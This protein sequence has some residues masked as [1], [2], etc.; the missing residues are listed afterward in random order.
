M[1]TNSVNTT[2]HLINNYGTSGC[3]TFIQNEDDE[4]VVAYD[5]E[6]SLCDARSTRSNV[7][8]LSFPTEPTA[9]LT[10]MKPD[11]DLPLHREAF[12][13]AGVEL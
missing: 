8:S 3:T 2:S 7:S 4:N 1:A 6:G 5:V 10:F 11:I 13:T 12:A 9:D